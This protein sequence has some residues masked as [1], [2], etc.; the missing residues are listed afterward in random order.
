MIP[1]QAPAG[2]TENI[3]VV[4][5]TGEGGG[6]F[7]IDQCATNIWVFIGR[8]THSLPAATDKNSLIVLTAVYFLSD[9]DGVIGVID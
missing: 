3:G 6:F 4:M 7:V 1:A 9:L 2:Q 8:H 5:L